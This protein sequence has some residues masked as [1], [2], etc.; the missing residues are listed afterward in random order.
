MTTGRINQVASPH[1]S[2]E[3]R[4]SVACAQ[5]DLFTKS[6]ITGGD[7]KTLSHTTV[8]STFARNVKCMDKFPS[9]GPGHMPSHHLS[10]TSKPGY[11]Q[12]PTVQLFPLVIYSTPCQ[13]LQLQSEWTTATRQHQRFANSITAASLPQSPRESR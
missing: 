3:L 9:P 13:N 11:E 12:H 5:P 7:S 1:K 10:W 4:S 8:Q 6:L 2:T